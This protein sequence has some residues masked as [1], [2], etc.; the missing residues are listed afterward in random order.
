MPYGSFGETA[1]PANP[2]G[3]MQTSRIAPPPAVKSTTSKLAQFV[4][5]GLNATGLL[6][7]APKPAAA[8]PQP[9]PI[10]NVRVLEAVRNDSDRRPAGHA[11]ARVER[12]DDPEAQP[13]A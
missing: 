6:G 12:E 4:S 7:A 5:S 9:K 13:A 8:A 3:S 10:E 2:P 11:L 1:P